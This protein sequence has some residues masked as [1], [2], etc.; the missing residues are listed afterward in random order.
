MNE[1]KLTLRIENDSAARN[2][3]GLTE[4]GD[5]YIHA[6][7]ILGIEPVHFLVKVFNSEVVNKVNC[8]DYIDVSGVLTKEENCQNLIIE[9]MDVTRVDIEGHENA[10]RWDR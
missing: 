9:T 4:D 7:V 3:I 2:A 8:G 1:I 5:A 6:Y 10:Y